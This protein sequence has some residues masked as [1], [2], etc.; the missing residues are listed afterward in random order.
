MAEEGTVQRQHEPPASRPK[1]PAGYGFSRGPE[2]LLPWS[3]AAERLERAR[4]YWLVTATPEGRPHATPVWGVWVDGAL[5]ID[6]HPASRWARD[7]AS[8]PTVVVHL[9]S[10]D[11]VV[12]VEGTAE[13]LV[14]DSQ[15]GTRIV[16]AWN[17]KYGRLA[18]EPVTSG[19][20]CLRPHAVRAWSNPSLEDGTRWQF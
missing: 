14:T 4:N 2:G 6:G 18:P 20:F 5:Y 17:A 8:N 12:I 3:H 13:D 11:D 10:G 19:L 9:E 15:L 1:A 7:L 16:D